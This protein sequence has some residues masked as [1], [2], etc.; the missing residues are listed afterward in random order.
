MPTKM[1]LL[2]GINLACKYMVRASGP[3]LTLNAST[4][5]VEEDWS[6]IVAGPT[7]GDAPLVCVVPTTGTITKGTP[8]TD[9]KG[10]TYTPVRLPD[11]LS[12]YNY[13]QPNNDHYA[14]I[15]DSRITHDRNS[16]PKTTTG[17]VRFKFIDK[18][19][20]D[21]RRDIMEM[22]VRKIT[23]WGSPLSTPEFEYQVKMNSCGLGFS[24]ARAVFLPDRLIESTSWTTVWKSGSGQAELGPENPPRVAAVTAYAI[25]TNILR[26]GNLISS[27][28]G[29]GDIAM[30]IQKFYAQNNVT[31]EVFEGLTGFFENYDDDPHFIHSEEVFR[32]GLKT[33]TERPRYGWW[34][35][36]TRTGMERSRDFYIN[37]HWPWMPGSRSLEALYYLFKFADTVPPDTSSDEDG[38]RHCYEWLKDMGF[39]GWGVSRTYLIGNLGDLD[40]WGQHTPFAERGV[41]LPTNIPGILQTIYRA[42]FPLRFLRFLTDGFRIVPALGNPDATA[43]M[44]N[45]WSTH[46]TGWRGL[47]TSYWGDHLLRFAIACG[48]LYPALERKGDTT[49]ANEVKGWLLRACDVLLSLQLPWNGVFVDDEGNENCQ[50]HHAGGLATT[51]RIVGGVPRSCRYKSLVEAAASQVG[52]AVSNS[53]TQQGLVPSEH[54]NHYELSIGVILAFALAYHAVDDGHGPTTTPITFPPVADAGNGQVVAPSSTVTLDASWSSSPSGRALT[55]SWKK[56]SG[57]TVDLRNATTANPFF[58]APAAVGKLVFEVTVSDGAS[59][60]KDTVTIEVK[61]PVPAALANLRA[62]PGSGQATL[63]WDNPNNASIIRYEYRW[64]SGSA[65]FG[66]W[67]SIPNSQVDGLPGV[68]HAR[69][70]E[71]TRTGLTNTRSYSFQIRAVSANGAGPEVEVGPV[72]PS[73]IPALSLNEQSGFDPYAEGHGL[74]CEMGDFDGD[75]FDLENIDTV[76]TNKRWSGAEIADTSGAHHWWNAYIPNTATP[77]NIRLVVRGGPDIDP[78]FVA[79]RK[80]GFRVYV[81]RGTDRDWQYVLGGSDVLSAAS[82][83]SDSKTIV[84]ADLTVL[85]TNGAG[86]WPEWFNSARTDLFDVKIEGAPFN[87]PPV[88]VATASPEAA[89]PRATVTLDGSGSSDPDGDALT[90]KWE[91]D[92]GSAAAAIASRDGVTLSDPTAVKP[93]FTAPTHAT[94]LK[95]KLTVTDSQGATAVTTVTVTVRVPNRLSLADSV[96]S[97]LVRRGSGDSERDEVRPARSGSRPPES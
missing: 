28:D 95:F 94:T 12:A 93:T 87:R 43:Y 62:T 34:W 85:L 39:D 27:V 58:T 22:E 74:W 46:V 2:N 33:Q 14:T 44:Y 80:W 71:W 9:K 25:M 66:R 38:I 49:R 84:E 13:F 5:A 73:A 70:L 82:F 83:T 60:S 77:A 17:W 61:K 89:T 1:Q 31:F 90:Y 56:L 16:S 32:H 21:N 29:L 30:G 64:R 57:P 11:G 97:G 75:P 51:Y 67:M 7:L 68:V 72:Y 18:D 4:G 36:P 6:T 65:P 76:G 24:S 40:E 69:T 52:A 47:H 42:A 45:N 10:V 63:S 3:D 26:T 35:W 55:Y 59:T 37:Y 78:Q 91:Q 50:V 20:P 96:P 8:I 81:K 15:L 19:Q 23:R 92:F 88:A 41:S 48:W 86:D 54:T 53:Q 79:G